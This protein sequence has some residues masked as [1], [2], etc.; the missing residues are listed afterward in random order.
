MNNERL[1]IDVDHFGTISTRVE[2]TAN[3]QKNA[4][5]PPK[6]ADL[7]GH[8]AMGECVMWERAE[9]DEGVTGGLPLRASSRSEMVLGRLAGGFHCFKVHGISSQQM[10]VAALAVGPQRLSSGV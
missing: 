2:I 10:D 6:T 7:L 9:G 1:C 3:A 4:V 8:N 5:A